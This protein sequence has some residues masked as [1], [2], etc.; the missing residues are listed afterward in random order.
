MPDESCT[1]GL[2]L[3][4]RRRQSVLQGEMADFFL[5]VRP[6]GADETILTGV[7]RASPGPTPASS[8]PPP[9]LGLGSAQLRQALSARGAPAFRPPSR[10]RANILRRRGCRSN[11]SCPAPR[12]S[13]PR[14]AARG[15]AQPNTA[16]RA[17]A[18]PHT[19]RGRAHLFARADTFVCSRTPSLN[20]YM[21]R[22]ACC[23]LSARYALDT[24]LG[25]DL[26][27]R[28]IELR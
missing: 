6:R 2:C 3:S 12:A 20:A 4:A 22:L 9:A 7:T 1:A 10:P 11:C 26:G 21:R 15:H 27:V 8:R 16:V 28:R 18:S 19:P 24:R 14:R 23:L 17:L 25:P 5:V 13:R